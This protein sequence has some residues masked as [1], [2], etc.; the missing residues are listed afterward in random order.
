[1]LFYEWIKSF[2]AKQC[3]YCLQ[4]FEDFENAYETLHQVDDD[5]FTD[6]DLVS[7]NFLNVFLVS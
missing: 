2:Y 1:M 3:A 6:G 4:Y 5:V 7:G